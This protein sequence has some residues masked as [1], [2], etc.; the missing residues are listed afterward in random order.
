M[1]REKV[2]LE[3][4][5]LLF[6]YIAR[7]EAGEFA[8]AQ[9]D[10]L[11]TG[12]YTPHVNEL[13]STM[14]Q[15]SFELPD[16]D[17]LEWTDEARPFLQD[18]QRIEEADMETVRKLFTLAVQADRLNRAHFPHLCVSGVILALLRRLRAFSA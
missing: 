4:F 15:A 9:S 8:A 17:W 18:P 12:E 5:E 10:Y 1:K 14:V 3:A 2:N 7:L 11:S 13:L 16:F 6:P